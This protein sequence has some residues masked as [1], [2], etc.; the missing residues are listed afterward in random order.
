MIVLIKRIPPEGENLSGTDPCSIMDM[1]EPGVHFH[2]DI[3]YD[4]HVQIQSNALLATGS[5]S[6]V[7]TLNC[8]RCLKEF[9]QPIKVDQFVAHHPLQGEDSVDLTPNIREDILLE[10]PQRALCKP[11]CNGLCPTCG[12]DL[13]VNACNCAKSSQDLRWQALDNI[14]LK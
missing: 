11:N 14:K 1:D 13:N 12:Q 6:T 9:Q 5:L 4:L 2:E 3:A 8:G 10:L 7:A